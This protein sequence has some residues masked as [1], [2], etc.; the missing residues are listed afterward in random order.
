MSAG[1]IMELKPQI[2]N[3]WLAPFLCPRW[4]IPWQPTRGP[5]PLPGTG[6]S[7]GQWHAHTHKQA[8]YRIRK[9]HTQVYSPYCRHAPSE[10]NVSVSPAPWK[11]W[12][13]KATPRVQSPDSWWVLSL[14]GPPVPFLTTAFTANRGQKT[15]F[16]GTFSLT[17][18]GWEGCL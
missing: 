13:E 2:K 4:A 16:L 7:G 8:Q 18:G 12:V 15:R 1:M 3:P 10:V 5:L 14:W 6:A 17:V 9:G 11:T